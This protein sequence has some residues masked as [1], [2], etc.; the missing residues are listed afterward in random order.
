MSMDD[1][2]RP[3]CL[4][5]SREAGF[6]KNGLA[7]SLLRFVLFKTTLSLL[8]WQLAS[9][10]SHPGTVQEPEEAFFSIMILNASIS[11]KVTDLLIPNIERRLQ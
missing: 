4:L 1:N 5:R 9:Q 7:S 11:I 6:G 10:N 8:R 3:P 2:S